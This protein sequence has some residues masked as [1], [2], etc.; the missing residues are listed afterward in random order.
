MKTTVRKRDSKA[1]P[2]KVENIRGAGT[3]VRWR[4]SMTQ[5]K[6]AEPSKIRK[7]IVP[8]SILPLVAL[9]NTSRVLVSLAFTLATLLQAMK[10]GSPFRGRYQMPSELA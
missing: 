7:L 1:I 2:S 6:F 4:G 3:R 10:V 8:L 5:D 9:H